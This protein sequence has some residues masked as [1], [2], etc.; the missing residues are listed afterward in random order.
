MCRMV[1]ACQ[2]FN[3]DPMAD[4]S[5]HK[6]S[7]QHRCGVVCFT[8]VAKF[9]LYCVRPARGQARHKTGQF[10]QV[11]DPEQRAALPH[12]DLGIRSHDVGPLRRNQTDRAIIEA[13][14]Q[15]PAGSIVSLADTN[16]GAA[17]KRVEGVGY[18]NTL[19]QSEGNACIL[20]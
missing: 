3:A 18:N 12:D 7:F 1:S 14:Q 13:Q 2:G 15:A 11:R 20:D 9:S 17:A 16:G 19:R 10:R 8:I 5:A 6:P 4:T